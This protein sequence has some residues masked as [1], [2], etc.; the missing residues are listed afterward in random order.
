MFY[1]VGF[2][3]EKPVW[4]QGSIVLSDDSVLL[5]EVSVQ[6]RFD[7]ILFKTDST[8]RFLHAHQVKEVYYFDHVEKIN[9]K[10]LTVN[11]EAI[12]VLFEIVVDGAVKVVR[13]LHQENDIKMHYRYYTLSNRELLP[14]NK[15]R[16]RLFPRLAAA[17]PQLEQVVKKERWNVNVM[18]DDIIIIQFYNSVLRKNPM[19]A[20]R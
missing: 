4:F 3:A 1:S 10:F 11:D 15:F 12:P 17:M 6:S 13:K 14:I 18:R 8:F 16:A 19:T 7:A 2:A 20:S 9:R 5:G